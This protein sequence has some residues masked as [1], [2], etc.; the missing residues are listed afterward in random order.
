MNPEGLAFFQSLAHKVEG[1]RILRFLAAQVGKN[2]AQNGI[3][4][5]R[6]FLF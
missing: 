5:F 6:L 4:F 3:L 1:F 2:V